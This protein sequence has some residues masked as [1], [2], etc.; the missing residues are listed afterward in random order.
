MELRD[1]NE[2]YTPLHLAS[3]FGR[4][5]TVGTLADS[6]AKLNRRSVKDKFTALM[7]SAREGHKLVVSTLIAKGAKSN[8]CDTYGWSALHFAASWGRKETAHLIIVEGRADVNSRQDSDDAVGG[9]TAL[10]IAT[11]GHQIDLMKLLLNYGADVNLPEK[12]H[13]HAPIAC[14][15]ELGDVDTMQVLIDYHAELN[16]KNIYTGATPLMVAA[17]KGHRAAIMLLL[18]YFSDVNILDNKASSSLDYAGRMGKLD[19][20]LNMVIQVSPEAKTNLIPW[21]EMQ[22]PFMKRES[23]C[24]GPS[25]YFNAVQ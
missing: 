11:K 12:R 23:E 13:G 3:Q 6:G 22:A 20:Y 4:V 19:T 16:I 5:E 10:I 14:A 1:F 8:I 17:A 18:N 2:G 7:L 21:L 15:A 24:G 25:V 9:T